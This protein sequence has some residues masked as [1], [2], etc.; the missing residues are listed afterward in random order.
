MT[1]IQFEGLTVPE[2]KA[3]K[4]ELHT[5]LPNVAKS[6][7][8]AVAE[9]VI[10]KYVTAAYEGNDQWDVWIRSPEFMQGATLS[11]RKLNAI[12]KAMPEEVPVRLLEGEAV[13][14]LSSSQ[15]SEAQ[16]PLGIRNRRADA[17][18]KEPATSQD[19]VH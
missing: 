16:K 12:L 1:S 6:A 8:D 10:G 19:I 3:T 9:E 5:L 2:R 4:A 15:L 11:K 13:L 17:L 18:T 14:K 7:F